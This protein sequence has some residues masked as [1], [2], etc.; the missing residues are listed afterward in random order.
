VLTKLPLLARAAHVG[1]LR[2]LAQQVVSL[3]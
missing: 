2:V 3:N 1:L